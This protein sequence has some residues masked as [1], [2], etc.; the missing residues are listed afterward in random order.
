MRYPLI[1]VIVPIYNVKI[2]LPKCIESICRQTYRN[3]EIILVDDGSTDGS[4]QICEDYAAKDS[5]IV[6]VH[7]PNGGVVSARKAGARAATG[8][9]I[10]SV[11]G[12]DWIGIARMEN[13][14]LNG[15]P[16]GADMIYLNGWN[17]QNGSGFILDRPK[18]IPGLYKK[19]DVYPWLTDTNKCFSRNVI[20]CVVCWAIKAD[21]YKQ[22]MPQLT[23]DIS[24]ADDVV[25]IYLCLLESK[26][27]YIL[28]DE[29]YYYV[30][31]ESSITHQK[32]PAYLNSLFYAYKTIK[33]SLDSHNC[34]K[35]MYRRL[36]FSI[37]KVLLETDYQIVIKNST[38]FLYPYPSV[39]AGNRVVIYA[40]GILGI[41]LIEGITNSQKYTVTGWV[42][43]I[44][45]DKTV[46]GFSPCAP[47][48]VLSMEY[49]N[50]IVAL[51]DADV[52]MK[53][54][55]FLLSMGVEESR[56]ACMDAGVVSKKMLE[57]CL[58]TAL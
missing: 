9:Y 8:D 35:E 37:T 46:H 25:A 44:V 12:D 53:V 21:L 26:N 14:A 47:E 15:I 2:Y 51:I 39:K 24:M 1:S 34:G 10:V 6:V 38:A 3:L 7:K 4:G 23:D 19:E 16:S 5:R 43:R 49:D 18:A 55:N 57:Q 41:R 50:I 33:Q 52:S 54:R 22:V 17:R 13:L 29:G 27:V 31:R 20:T 32:N 56:I 11:D 48:N 30:M 45:R 40:A 28:E 58:E 42:D 36:V